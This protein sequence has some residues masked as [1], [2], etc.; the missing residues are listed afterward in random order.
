M[1]SFIHNTA[2]AAEQIS[3]PP[4]PVFLFRGLSPM[5]ALEAL[6]ALHF[7]AGAAVAF[8]RRGANGWQEC[9]ACL[10][11]ELSARWP[12]LKSDFSHDAYFSLASTYQQNRV[13]RISALGLP[14]WRRRTERLRWLNVV[15]LDLDRHEDPDFSAARLFE[16]FWREL[17][18][19]AIP[20]PTFVVFS[21]RGIWALWQIVDHNNPN[22]PVPAF[23]DK[24]ELAQRISR[25][26]VKRFAPLGADRNVTDAARV[27][28]VP[29]SFNSQAAPEN[30]RVRFFR[31]S[32]TTSTLPELA[33]ALDIRARK[34]S[35]PGERT[36]KDRAKANAARLRWR[37]P[38]DGFCALWR[39]RGGFTKFTRR[40]AIYVLSMLLRKNR[41]T[42][43]QILTS[44]MEL[45]ESFTPALSAAAVK[46]A[47]T[48]SEKA[49]S[50]NISNARL[51][52][53]L[54][55]TAKE[56]AALPRSFRPAV[57]RK[58]AQIA[59]RRA[60]LAQELSSDREHPSTRR[61]VRLLAEKH[62]ITVTRFTVA[63]DMRSM[64]GA[65]SLLI[66]P[67]APLCI[68]K[69]NAPPLTE[70][71]FTTTKAGGTQKKCGSKRINTRNCSP[72]WT[73][74]GGTA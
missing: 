19:Q 46:R 33:A 7:G 12:A 53:M 30:S 36:A 29:D 41:A 63:R 72:T 70:T 48:A 34:V 16:S 37:Y 47:I 3:P 11:A 58:S 18:S 20:L 64:R 62:G 71:E 59:A 27:M 15:A 68:S 23:P 66:E 1:S 10:A 31:A 51:A 60:L 61:L 74:P 65:F 39:M 69:K 54:K 32:A 24:C 55:I 22:Q 57:E 17:E 35:L 44:C 42:P 13:T 8:A 38:L 9:G 4:Q 26:L 67:R 25:E 21:G 43:Q 28:R 14:L 52:E 40:P 73:Q 5:S 6:T 45:A 2:H 49:I 56:Q 50:Y